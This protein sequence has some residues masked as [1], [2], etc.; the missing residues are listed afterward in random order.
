ME[1]V[2]FGLMMFWLLFMLAAALHLFC[3]KVLGISLLKAI[4][5]TALVAWIIK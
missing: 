2:L 4:G 1:N 3:Q 5:I